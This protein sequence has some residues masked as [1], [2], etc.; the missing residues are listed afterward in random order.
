MADY[1]NSSDQQHERTPRN[2]GAPWGL[3]PVSPTRFG[4]II[5]AEQDTAD[6]SI[7]PEQRVFDLKRDKLGILNWVMA[8]VAGLV[9]GVVMTMIVAT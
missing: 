4:E 3:D 8:V 2:A 6:Y 9:L 7:R 5:D 1:P